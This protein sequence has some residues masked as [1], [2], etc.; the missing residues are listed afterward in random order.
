M[1]GARS[2]SLE[3]RMITNKI[4]DIS[5]PLSTMDCDQETR[6]QRESEVAGS[7]RK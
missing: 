1:R 2:G 3:Q 6:L 5:Q 7:I 4:L